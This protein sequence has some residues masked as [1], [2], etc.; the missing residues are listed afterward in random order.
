MESASAL[1]HPAEPGEIRA[2]C[3]RAF[4][5]RARIADCRPLAGGKFNTV[6]RIRLEHPPRDIVLR[7]APVRQD[8]LYRFERVLIRSEAQAYPLLARSGV[9]VPEVLLHDASRE[10]VPREYLITGFLPG[11]PLSE[12]GLP[13]PVRARILH[14]LGSHGR[15]IHSHT[16]PAFGWFG[17]GYPGSNHNDWPCFLL[18]MIDEIEERN[19][20][21]GFA[22]GGP[23]AALRRSVEREEGLLRVRP[24]LLHNDLHPGNILV[25]EGP[26][27]PRLTAI[28]DAD[29]MLYGDPEFELGTC[30]LAQGAFR[31]G[32]GTGAESETAT[33]EETGFRRTL[34]TLFK[35]LLDLDACTVQL[36]AARSAALLA[37]SVSDLAE[38]L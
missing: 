27:G 34:Y 29:R 26:E 38:R 13:E 37:A 36:G 23:I 21:F 31:E 9:P 19:G 2:I 22:P 10:I 12:C 30:A 8:L 11:R 20:R 25:G 33:A 18:D 16:G 1:F 35:D 4:G 3:A 5:A 6:Y 24:A 28:L 14:T 32:Y 7:L 15:R 17:S